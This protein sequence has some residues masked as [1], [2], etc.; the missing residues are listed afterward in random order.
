MV[1]EY[2]LGFAFGDFQLGFRTIPSVLLIRK[3][4]PEWQRGRLNGIGG[5]I[6]PTDESPLAAMVREFEEET[7]LATPE[8]AWREFATMFQSD[9]N[10][11][12]TVTCFASDTIEIG[13][14]R[15]MEDELVELIPLQAVTNGIVPTIE[16]LSW[17]IPLA[18]DKNAA[19]YA[20]TN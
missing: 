20:I 4:R 19:T 2:V 18:L 11:P 6:E 12:W 10:D 7:G 15:T 17:L 9:D 3:A 1:K 8:S 5:K 13:N 14:A 16:N